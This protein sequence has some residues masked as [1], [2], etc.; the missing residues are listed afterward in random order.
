MRINK[1]INV[2]L[3]LA[4]FICILYVA[5]C[6]INSAVERIIAE[7]FQSQIDTLKEKINSQAELI[8][9]LINIKEKEDSNNDTTVDNSNN[10]VAAQ[11]QEFNYII[12]NGG[13]TIT[14]YN[15]NKTSVQIPNQIKQ[16]PVLKIGKNAFAESKVKSVILPA[17]CKEVDWFA[18]YGCFALTTIYISNDV[19][20]IGYGAFESCSKSLV[21]YCEENSYAQKYAQ[22]FGIKY[23]NFQ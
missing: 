10:S 16:M 17:S 5:G 12:E 9:S 21:I 7:N 19:T 18:F 8:N 22:S 1:I 2:L 14:K 4:I 20:S 23:S 15:G 6:E 13:V 3:F 11:T